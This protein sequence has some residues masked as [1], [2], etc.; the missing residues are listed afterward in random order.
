MDAFVRTACFIDG[1]WVDGPE[2]ITVTDP[3]TGE[4]MGR[5]PDLGRAG[6]QAAIEAAARALPAWRAAG[7]NTRADALMAIHD[8]I[9]AHKEDLAHLLTREMGKPLAEARGEL[10]NGASFFRWFAEEARR[11]Y[12]EI[13]PS[14][15]TDK[16]ILVTREPIGVAAAITPW[17]FPAGMI[18]RKAAAALA[19]GC[20]MVIK[21]SELTPFSALAYGCLAEETGLPKGVLNIVTGA[22]EPIADA[23]VEHD[24]VRKI[25]F[26]GSTR[27]GRML[28]SKALA[29]M[30]RVSMELGGHA[31]LI[32]FEDADLDAAVLGAV[33]SKF[34]NAGQTCICANRIIVQSPVYEAFCDRFAAAVTD[35]RVGAGLEE[36]VAIGPL[37]N[38]AA[39]DK[40]ARQIADA[41]ALGGSVMVGGARHAR[42]GTFFEPTIIRDA[43]TDMLCARE[44]TFGPMAPVFRFKTEGEAVAMANDTDYGLAAYVYTRDLG[45]SFRMMEALEYGMVGLNE[46]VISTPIAPFGGV[47]Q[48]GLGREGGSQGIDEY[49]NVKYALI[50]G[51]E[52]A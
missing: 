10:V 31:P 48:S 13:V 41:R 2:T 25:S 51:V 4:A 36:G 5:V 6:A 11:V 3:A 1:A 19:A 16:R 35:L 37:I 50:G 42:G 12:G 9:M 46:T 20:T 43:R 24:A 15:W 21:P 34:R 45:R 32:V 39:V 29:T 27:V 44:E 30:T 8:A 28:A 52:S 23:F 7:P 40:V 14:P 18:A 26:T 47:K 22:P 17:N 38:E 49:L 33:T